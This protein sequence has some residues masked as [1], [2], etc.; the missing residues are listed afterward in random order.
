M[1][2]AKALS[3]ETYTTS[4]VSGSPPSSPDRTSRSRQVM[5]A[6]SVLPEPVGAATRVW[7][8][9]A[10]AGHPSACAPV[11]ASKRLLNHSRISG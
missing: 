9:R 1:S 3:G 11:G 7:V 6:A 10:M 8:P 2:F 5:K 4:V